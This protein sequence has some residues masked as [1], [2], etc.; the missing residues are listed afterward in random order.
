[1]R[2][3]DRNFDDKIEELDLS[4]QINLPTKTRLTSLSIVVPLNYKLHVRNTG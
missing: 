3:F 4:L 2:V 1:M